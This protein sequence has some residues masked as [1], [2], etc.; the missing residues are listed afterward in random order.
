MAWQAGARVVICNAD[1]TP[2]D[3]IAEVLVREPLE[4]ALQQ[5]VAGDAGNGLRDPLQ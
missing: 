5:I 1:P 3:S 2:Y 4:E